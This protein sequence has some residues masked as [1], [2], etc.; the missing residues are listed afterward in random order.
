MWIWGVLFDGVGCW[1]GM[2]VG[3]VVG[4][5]FVGVDRLGM[6]VGLIC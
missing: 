2:V 5:G 1:V 4:V 6:V 3:F